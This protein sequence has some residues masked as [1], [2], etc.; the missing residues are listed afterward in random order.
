MPLNLRAHLCCPHRPSEICRG[1]IPKGIRVTGEFRFRWTSGLRGTRFQ[2]RPARLGR[3]QASH[4]QTCFGCG[5]RIPPTMLLPIH[6]T[7]LPRCDQQSAAVK[8][9]VRTVRAHARREALIQQLGGVCV[10]CG[11]KLGLQMDLLVSD[12]GRH[13]GLSFRDRQRFY[14]V[15]AGRGNVALRCVRCHQVV[16]AARL[17]RQ[18]V[19]GILAGGVYGFR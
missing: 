7:S 1:P 8:E 10:D 15:Q 4:R 3:K 19:H 5:A 14:L 6:Q 16:S 9:S 12:G 11:T 13:H 18:R 2:L 17:A